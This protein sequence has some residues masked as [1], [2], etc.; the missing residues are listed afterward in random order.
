MRS[1]LIFRPINP[2]T[3]LAASLLFIGYATITFDARI[4]GL[5]FAA[6]A[7]ALA[8]GEKI[9]PL[10]L[11]RSLF[12]FALTGIGFFLTQVLFSAQAENYAQS[13]PL[14]D[15]ALS[16]LAAGTAMFLRALCFGS[17]SYFFVRTTD[18]GDLAR[19]LMQH[20]R[21]PAHLAYSVFAAVQL[22]PTLSNDLRQI[23][24]AH[25]LRSEKT[26]RPRW[27]S[28]SRYTRF[29]V[30]LLAG[31]MRRATRASIGMEC[32]GL[33]REMTR[34][35]LHESRFSVRDVVFLIGAISLL[36]AVVMAA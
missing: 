36:A 18:P 25:A 31:A 8:L 32:R 16:P 35:S 21:L 15:G 14:Y 23:E 2:L 12:P 29:P 27:W 4:L 3:K 33:S 5:L 22:L 10:A 13:L 17:F 30:P 19:A 11:A 34:T 1:G 9:P 6:V 20:A 28:P 7:V 24:L 26:T